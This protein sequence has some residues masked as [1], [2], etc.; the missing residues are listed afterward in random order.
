MLCSAPRPSVVLQDCVRRP[1]SGGALKWW[2]LAIDCWRFSHLVSISQSL[3]DAL[4]LPPPPHWLV[5]KENTSVTMKMVVMKMMDPP[6][7]GPALIGPPQTGLS[8]CILVVV[9]VYTV[10]HRVIG[11]KVMGRWLGW[12]GTIVPRVPSACWG[13]CAQNL[14]HKIPNWLTGQGMCAH[15]IP[16]TLTGQAVNAF[17]CIHSSPFCPTRGRGGGTYTPVYQNPWHTD[18]TRGSTIHMCMYTHT[19]AHMLCIQKHILFVSMY[20]SLS[21]S[22]SLY[23]TPPLGRH[24]CAGVFTAVAHRILST[25]TKQGV[26]PCPRNPDPL[27]GQCTQDFWEQCWCTRVYVITQ[28]EREFMCE[29]VCTRM[30]LCIEQRH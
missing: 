15:K 25:L 29:W 10:F 7:M 14:R 28:K 8:L 24:P 30:H 2:R 16:I 27:S 6:L 11:S 17:L 13:F 19:H 23:P 26:P 22:L 21:L 12:V 5:P 20:L 9:T 1:L 18:R 3:P 4:P